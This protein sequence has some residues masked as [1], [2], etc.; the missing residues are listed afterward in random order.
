MSL[1]HWSKELENFSKKHFDL[2]DLVSCAKY[3]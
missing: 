3:M 1:N 2:S